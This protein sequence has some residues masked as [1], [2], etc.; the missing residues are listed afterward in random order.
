MKEMDLLDLPEDILKVIDT[1][2]ERLKQREE[3]FKECDEQIKYLKKNKMYN[4]EEVG[5]LL[6]DRL[7]KSMYSRAEIKEYKRSRNIIF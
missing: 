6:Y 1:H 4:E 2:V 7:Y 5:E 3:D